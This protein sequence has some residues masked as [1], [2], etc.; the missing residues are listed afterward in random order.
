[1]VIVAIPLGI[2]LAQEAGPV[3]VLPQEVSPGETFDV[4]VTFT[5][6]VDEFNSIG[7]ADTAPENWNV[8][9]DASWC[10]PAP[11]GAEA[12]GG[13]TAKFAW[14]GGPEVAAGEN[15]TAMYKVTV[16]R[17]TPAGNYTF[18]NGS[19]GYCIRDN[20]SYLD[21][22]EVIPVGGIAV[23]EGAAGIGVWWIVGIVAGIAVV[24][25]VVFLK[26]KRKLS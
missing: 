24:V 2:A 14:A 5:A 23:A 26:R 7:L 9:V 16:P 3:R 22:P 18:N 8:T 15:F 6:P 17:N 1:L 12:A 25:A 21:Q 20:C 4:V 19:L 10:E 11:L 13:N